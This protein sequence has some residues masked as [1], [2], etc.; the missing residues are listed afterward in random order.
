MID[1]LHAATPRDDPYM[2]GWLWSDEPDP[3]ALRW[4]LNTVTGEMT[5]IHIDRC[6]GRVPKAVPFRLRFPSA[7]ASVLH[8]DRATR[9]LMGELGRERLAPKGEERQSGHDLAQEWEAFMN[10]GAEP[11]PEEEATNGAERVLAFDERGLVP[12]VP[13]FVQGGAGCAFTTSFRQQNLRRGA[14]LNGLDVFRLMTSPSLPFAAGDM[15]DPDVDAASNAL[16]SVLC[17]SSRAVSF[18]G[19][20]DP[21]LSQFRRQAADAF[22]VLAGLIADRPA[23]ADAVDSGRPLQPLLSEATGLTKAGLK[24]M[25]KVTMPVNSESAFSHDERIGGTDALGVNRT[26]MTRVSVT[27]PIETALSSLAGLPADRVPSANPEWTAYNDILAGMV[28]PVCNATEVERAAL[29]GA[30]NGSWADFR[31]SLAKAG[32]M[33]PDSLDR[34]AMTLVTI[35]AVE[36]LRM[37][38]RTAVMPQILASISS[39]REPVPQ[40]SIDGLQACNEAA[41]SL[42]LGSAENRK[43]LPAALMRIAR[44]YASRIPAMNA[45]DE[46]DGDPVEETTPGMERFARY[47]AT[48]FPTLTGAFHASNGCVIR[49]MACRADLTE[50]SRRLGHCVGVASSYFRKARR[51]ETYIYSVQNEAGD[52]SHST[53]QLGGAVQREEDATRANLH[54]I[55]HQGRS[56]WEPPPVARTAFNEFMAALK[57]GRI[58]I[59]AGQLVEWRAHLEATGQMRGVLNAAATRTPSWASALETNWSDATTRR[60]YWEEW[61]RVFGGRIASSSPEVIFTEKKAVDTLTFLSPAAASILKERARRAREAR[62]ESL[63]AAPE[64]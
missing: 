1:I 50:E 2:A 63:A 8:R 11:E 24:R 27:V 60:G 43:S 23:I 56:N 16:A 15:G 3:V 12:A 29:L 58:E 42:V 26:R 17:P 44:R 6:Q 53:F 39:T 59:N 10:A 18:Y 7:E 51:A 57:E 47:G 30:C 31:E 34:R 32:D 19:V 54:C 41:V 61:G 36:A 4:K 21:E 5:G 35:D 40:L 38:S 13:D 62:A 52:A 55:Q 46:R 22:P 28:L 48:S 37:F 14:P 45:L 49:P 25:G 33:P 64:P 20:R 9:I